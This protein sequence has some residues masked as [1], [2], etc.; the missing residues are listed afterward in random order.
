MNDEQLARHAAAALLEEAERH[1]GTDD[2]LAALMAT[3][4][5]TTTPSP[6]PPVRRRWAVIAAA[7][8]VAAAAIATVVVIDHRQDR[9]PA[10]GP[11]PATSTPIVTEPDATAPVVTETSTAPS[12][13]SP[14]IE[15]SST[16]PPST[17]PEPPEPAILV[18]DPA[19][20]AIVTAGPFGVWTQGP[21][22]SAKVTND[23]LSVAMAYPG[24]LAY[25]AQRQSG[26]GNWP[27]ADTVPLI[28]E[29]DD[30]GAWTSRPVW[31][32]EELIGWFRLHDV[33][34]VDGHP[35]GLV[36]VQQPLTATGTGDHALY[37]WDLE[38]DRLDKITDLD[39]TESFVTR[40]QLATNGWIAG[41]TTDGTTTSRR[42][43]FS[44]GSPLAGAVTLGVEDAPYGC[45]RCPGDFAVSE[46][47]SAMAWTEGRALVVWEASTGTVVRRIELPL[48]PDRRVTGIDLARGVAAVSVITGNEALTF[49]PHALLVELATGR[50]TELTGQTS[51]ITTIAAPLPTSPIPQRPLIDLADCREPTAW[52]H[53][54]PIVLYAR[55]QG[56]GYSI[57]L[58]ADP[59]LGAAAPFLVA[60]RHFV[61][62][63]IG[64]GS[65][66]ANTLVIDGRPARMSLTPSGSVDASVLLEDGSE[67]YLRG[68][69]FDEFQL[70]GIIAGLTPRPTDGTLHGFD[71]VAPP[72]SGLEIMDEATETTGSS[73]GMRCLLSDGSASVAVLSGSAVFR[74]GASLDAPGLAWIVDDGTRTMGVLGPPQAAAEAL[75]ALREATDDEWAT[76]I[77]A[78]TAPPGPPTST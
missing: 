14:S 76:L 60:E 15:P 45:E 20:A 58:L 34:V 7:I 72:N 74:Y 29:P 36:E 28:Y 49:I 42:W 50:V 54:G 68:R 4:A 1:A 66:P 12:G 30:F 26:Y 67:M 46:D 8:T 32:D 25:V 59:D 10:V 64:A 61:G 37:T 69:G 47:G 31:P 6:A 3:A 22:G 41:E 13:P 73:A 5:S 71:F 23:V 24:K 56:D 44:I 43:M 19:A 77:A 40:L 53:S 62:Q 17:A 9:S 55:Q 70:T 2:A 78:G 35:I 21:G 65:D 52:E 51:A 39:P 38:A 48:E 18:G 27:A 16:A 33:N 75:G 63:H 57:Q 11:T